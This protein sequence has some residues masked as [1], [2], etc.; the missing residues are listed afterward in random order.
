MID[1]EGA[2]ILDKEANQF[3]RKVREAIWI[4]RK[5]ADTMNRDI[6]SFTLDHVYDSLLTPS[7]AGNEA[8]AGFR[9]RSSEPSHF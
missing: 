8:T 4:R 7:H 5:G 2:T 3:K 6:G 9:G 1:W